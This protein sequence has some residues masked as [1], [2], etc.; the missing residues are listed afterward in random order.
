[1]TR[2]SSPGAGVGRAR[3]SFWAL[4]L[5]AVLA[6]GSLDIALRADAGPLTG[7]RVAASG[8]VAVLA[9][10]LA[11]RVML[12]LERARRGQAERT[13]SGA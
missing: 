4:V 11:A 5:I 10:A 13:R 1:M 2:E 7:L 12:A 3:R 8:L 6:A 9:L